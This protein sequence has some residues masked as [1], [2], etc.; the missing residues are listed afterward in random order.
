MVS[1]CTALANDYS[2]FG[3]TKSMLGNLIDR[4]G[5]NKELIT[6]RYQLTELKFKET[7]KN[8]ED[9]LS[10]FKEDKKRF[11]ESYKQVLSKI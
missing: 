7:Y 4:T 6:R 1:A 11:L 8:C 10:T 9:N 2:A 5:E 3:K